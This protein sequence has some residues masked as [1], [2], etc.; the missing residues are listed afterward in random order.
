MEPSVSSLQYTA[1]AVSL[2]ALIW[3]VVVDC[4]VISGDAVVDGPVE[5]VGVMEVPVVVC[6]VAI[7]VAGS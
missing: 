5:D 7:F 6:V 2:F 4:E 1:K 3:V